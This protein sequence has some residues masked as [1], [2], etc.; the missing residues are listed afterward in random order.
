MGTTQR[1]TPGVTGEPNWGS[2]NTAVTS[3]ANTVAAEQQAEKDSEKA[4]KKEQLAPTPANQQALDTINRRLAQLQKRRDRNLAAAMASLIRTGGG[5]GSVSKGKSHSL[6]KAGV[7]GARKLS[8]F[9]IGV[10]SSGLAPTM[11]ALGFGSLKGKT[12]QEVID[13]LLIY[14]TGENNGMDEIAANMAS[15]QVM[16]K[17]AEGITSLNDLEAKMK[18]VVADDILTEL[19]ADFYGLYL[20]EHLSQ[21]FQEKITQIKGEPVSKETFKTIKEDIRDQVQALHKTTPLSNIDWAGKS[22]KELE[23]KIFDSIIQIFE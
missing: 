1:I 17:L 4:A 2:L 7:A 6:G 22:G 5:R 3:I 18:A 19:I 15:C 8:S 10:H 23:E 13:F 16:E 20:F 14:F 12:F 11:A 9:F 21:R